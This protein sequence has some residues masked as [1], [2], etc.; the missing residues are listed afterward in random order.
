[1]GRKSKKR[2]DLARDLLATLLGEVLAR[3]R[4]MPSLRF[5]TPFGTRFAIPIILGAT[6]ETEWPTPE[7]RVPDIAI[8]DHEGRPIVLFEVYHTHGVD[9][10]KRHD[11]ANYWWIEIDANAF[12]EQDFGVE[13]SLQVTDFN[14][15][16]YEYEITG[17]QGGLFD[18]APPTPRGS[19]YPFS[20]RRASDHRQVEIALARAR[21]RVVVS[22]VGMAHDARARIVPQHAFDAR[23]SGVRSIADDDDAGVLCIAHAD[24]A[25]VVEAHPGCAAGRVE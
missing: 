20:R 8:L 12:L 3:R 17:R 7:G 1:L 21:D 23:G 6:V 11:L 24:A 19:G 15:L 16:P 4:H 18:A 9:R 25:A 10:M 14:R 22:R 13:L 2:H 5:D